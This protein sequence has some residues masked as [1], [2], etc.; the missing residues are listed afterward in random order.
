MLKILLPLF[1]FSLFSF[2]ARAQNALSFDG[3]DDFIT[4]EYEGVLDTADRTFE[5]WVYVIE[6]TD[7]S[8]M[9]ILD[10]GRNA[11]GS[12]NTFSIDPVNMKAR[13]ISGGTNFS[14]LST[15]DN[16]VPHEEWIHVAFV[17]KDTLGTF[18]LNGIEVI[19]ANMSNINT[20][21]DFT[22]VRVGQRVSG[23]NIPFLGGLD[24]IRIWDV[25]RTAEEI[26]MYKDIEVCQGH[27]NLKLYFRFNQGISQGENQSIDMA[28]D[29]SGNNYTGTLNNFALS[30]GGSNWV[31]G[32]PITD[33]SLNSNI[34]MDGNTL[35]AEALDVEYQW[36]NCAD[37]S[38]IDGETNQSFTPTENGEYAVTV[39]SGICSLTSECAQVIVVNNENIA[40]NNNIAIYPNPSTGQLNIEF[41]L[42]EKTTDIILRDVTGK[43][44]HKYNC[45]NQQLLNIDLPD[46]PGVYF[47]EILTGTKKHVEK[48][49]KL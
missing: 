48:I 34:S 47:V 5:A 12:R 11:S 1:V 31:I 36:V 18:Y 37:F 13:Y 14:N 17:K 40:A 30:G 35:T 9:A 38:P 45:K 2:G 24:E 7:D 10:Y 46:T 29:D 16:S 15:P 8:N 4:T 19:S 39:S 21:A 22:P 20:P 27:P 23:G 33:N 42:V 32:T 43:I 49:I 41:T 25:A 28:I 6:G 26:L 3:M 44:V